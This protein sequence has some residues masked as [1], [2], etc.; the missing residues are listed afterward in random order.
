MSVDTGKIKEQVEYYFSN[1]NYAKDKFLQETAIKNNKCVPI[2]IL[3]TFQRMKQ[4]GVGVD[5][6]KKALE[7]SEVVETVGDSLKKIETQEYLDNRSDKD[8][9]RRIVHMDGFDLGATLDDLK[10]LLHEHCAPVKIL[11]RRTKDKAFTGS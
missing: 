3:L 7:G 8:I 11:M 10:G 4:L 9:A 2:T 5:E 1:S 6:V